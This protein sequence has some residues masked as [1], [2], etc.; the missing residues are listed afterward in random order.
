MDSYDRALALRNQGNDAE[1]SAALRTALEQETTAAEQFRHRRDAEPS[2]GI[3]YRSAASLAVQLGEFDTAESLVR[4]GLE[5]SPPAYVLGELKLL[6]ATSR[7]L[8]KDAADRR[9]KSKLFEP[10]GDP[11]DG[12]GRKT[13]VGGAGRNHRG[14][15][16][17]EG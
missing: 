11:V 6:L 8:R 4:R 16:E 3:L 2:R 15:A 7:P 13:R 12:A 10:P 14:S 17:N 9:R 5:G 1:A